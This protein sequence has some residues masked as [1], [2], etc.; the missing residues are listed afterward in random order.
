MAPEAADPSAPAYRAAGV[1]LAAADRFKGR[2]KALVEGTHGPEV[3]GGLGGF[4]GAFAI[5]ALEE[6]D[7]VLVATTDGVGTK[8]LVAQRAGRHDTI[9]RDLVHHCIDDLLASFARPLFLL[10]YVAMGRLEE[11]V[12][13]SIVAGLARA[14]R[15]AGVALV[16]GETAEMPDLYEPGEYDLAAFA[17]GV[18]PRARLARA[19]IEPGDVVL[20]LSSSGLHTNG[21]TLARRIVFEIAGAELDDDV[22]WGEGRWSDALLAVH[23]SYL[24]EVGPL[25]DDPALH[26]LA[27]V[28]GGGLV[29]NLPRALPIGLGARIDR[30]AWSVP[31]L[32]RWLAETGRIADEEMLR[33][34]NMGIGFCLVVD[35]AARERLARA[36][37]AI[38]IGHI[39]E[40]HGV[41]WA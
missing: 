36:T 6:R 24:R 8:V 25:L 17:V 3:L 22:P 26:A 30:S 16:G 7:P 1:D 2:L 10:D 38:A 41:E 4:G 9:G 12:A 32:F 35:P 33:V 27:H 5:G 19:A 34:F 31:P 29:G 14:C 20:G 39:E 23:R 40:G 13:L 37:G 18:T 15:D 11:G 21:Y 28:T